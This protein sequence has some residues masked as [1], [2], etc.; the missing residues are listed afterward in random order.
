MTQGPLINENAVKKVESHVQDALDKGGELLTGGNRHDLGGKFFEPTVVA[1]STRDMRVSTE[2]TV[3][4]LAPVYKFDTEEQV[5]GLANDVPAGLAAY[6]YS[7]DIGRVWRVAEE[8]EYGMVAI[9]VG[10]LASAETPFGGVKE[11]GIGREGSHHGV[12]EFIE[13]KYMLMSGLDK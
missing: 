3:S 11:S 10:I 2:E 12:D 9:N 4:P 1:N 8:L 5:I 6:F 13:M 7:R